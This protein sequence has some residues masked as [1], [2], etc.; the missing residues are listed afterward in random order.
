M[1]LSPAFGIVVNLI[2]TGEC[3]TV[4]S[5]SKAFLNP[6]KVP[7]NFGINRRV[8]EHFYFMSPEPDSHPKW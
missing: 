4:M 3:K 6:F 5:N 7:G 8:L 2:A 1:Y